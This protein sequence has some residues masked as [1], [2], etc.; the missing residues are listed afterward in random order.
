MKKEREKGGWCVHGERNDHEGDAD[1][2]LDRIRRGVTAS[3]ELILLSWWSLCWSPFQLLLCRSGGA[4]TAGWWNADVMDAASS[5][6]A[7]EILLFS[8]TWTGTAAMQEA[9][10]ASSSSF[11][12][13]SSL[14]CRCCSASQFSRLKVTK[15]SIKMAAELLLVGGGWGSWQDTY[16][17]RETR[18]NRVWYDKEIQR[19]ANLII[20]GRT[21][22]PQGILW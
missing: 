16:R 18:I 1:V 8:S 6:R 10:I 20:C 7:E 11:S 15:S 14:S 2:P 9:C 22:I 12:H 4:A 5:I 19:T 13:E 21:R 3:H 17:E